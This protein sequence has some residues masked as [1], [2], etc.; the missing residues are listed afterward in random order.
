V[1]S[2]E[3][4]SPPQLQA[5]TFAQAALFLTGHAWIGN[6]GAKDLL[7]IMFSPPTQEVVMTD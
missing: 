5:R 3:P 7:E 4:Y 2:H 6:K 1:L